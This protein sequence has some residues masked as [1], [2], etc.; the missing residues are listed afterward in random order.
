M[1]KYVFLD[2]LFFEFYLKLT[3]QKQENQW[4]NNSGNG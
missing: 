1:T 3:Q 4:K 2:S